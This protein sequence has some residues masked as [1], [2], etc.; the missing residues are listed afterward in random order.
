M[1]INEITLQIKSSNMVD[2]KLKKETLETIARLDNDVLEKLGQLAK[3]PK[4]ID[5]LRTSWVL[6][7]NLVM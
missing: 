5:K 1:Q 3:S 6:I 4:A 7:K 2:F